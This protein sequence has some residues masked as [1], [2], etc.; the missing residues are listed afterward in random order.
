MSD[1]TPEGRAA[2]L[3]RVSP[4]KLIEISH[5][6]AQGTVFSTALN[7]GVFDFLACESP[8]TKEQI[9]DAVGIKSARPQDFLNAL[10]AMGV[11]SKHKDADIDVYENTLQAATYCVKA[12]PMYMGAMLLDYGAIKTTSFQRLEDYLVNPTTTFTNFTDLYN[13]AADSAK[14]FCDMMECWVRI[15]GVQLPTTLAHVFSSVNTVLDVGGASGYISFQLAQ[16]FPHLH[17]LSADLPEVESVFKQQSQRYAT[18]VVERVHFK[19]INFLTGGVLD[20]NDEPVDAVIFGHILHDW[21]EAV[22]KDLL[23]KAFAA[24]RPGGK[25]IIYEFM[26]DNEESTRLYSML[27]SLHMQLRCRGAQFTFRE[28]EAWLEEAGFKGME[29]YSLNELTDA[30]V[31]TKP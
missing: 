3:A 6:I 10:V 25:V 17:A 21:E 26:L 18:G 19:S 13:T 28:A 7:L 4:N 30:I 14:Q 8:A 12:S 31:A 1:H 2:A 9:A 11:L 15:I 5:G 22:K 24:L 16:R 20:P 27:M 29:T 23:N